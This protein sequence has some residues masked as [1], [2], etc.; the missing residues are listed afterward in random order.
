MEGYEEI[1]IINPLNSGIIKTIKS[2][3]NCIHFKKQVM[4]KSGKNPI[5]WDICDQ[6]VDIPGHGAKYILD[7]IVHKNVYG[8]YEPP[9]FDGEDCPFHIQ[10]LRSKKINNIIK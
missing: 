1:D 6:R 7:S 9:G 5:H 8:Y 3:N 4:V 10:L 2:C